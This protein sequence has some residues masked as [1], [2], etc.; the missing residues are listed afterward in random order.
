MRL[1]LN[2]RISP[3]YDHVLMAIT[4]VVKLDSGCV[5]KVFKLDGSPV[6]KLADFFDLDADVFFIYGNE[7]VGNDDFQ[8]EPDERK[9]INQTKKTLKNGTVRSGPKPKMP[10][11]SHNETFGVCAEEEIFN[12]IRSDSLPFEI[13]Q[14]FS[15]GQIVGDGNFA[16]VLKLKDKQGSDCEYA[17]KIIDKSKCKGKVSD[18]YFLLV[19]VFQK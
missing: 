8:L 14:R 11:K 12:G 5:R 10:V 19:T 1:L 9:A 4:Q 2:K 18:F 6:L 3:T 17:L 15:L 7:R 13:Q 16:V